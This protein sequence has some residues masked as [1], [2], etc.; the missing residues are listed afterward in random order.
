MPDS[1]FSSIALPERE[2]ERDHLYADTLQYALSAGVPSPSS[3]LPLVAE[4]D[5]ARAQL[6]GRC[7]EPNEGDHLEECQV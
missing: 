7:I 3:E 1:S 5:V 4:T 6:A 2:T